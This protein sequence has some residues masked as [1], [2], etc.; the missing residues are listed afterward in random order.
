MIQTFAILRSYEEKVILSYD[1][2]GQVNDFEYQPRFET[3]NID[4]TQ[5]ELKKVLEER[6]RFP[7]GHYIVV[8]MI[9]S[10]TI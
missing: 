8:P 5:E 6:H 4:L 10:F 3:F 2:C 1:Q 7:K 9:Q